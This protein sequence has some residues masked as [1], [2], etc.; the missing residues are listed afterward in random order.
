MYCYYTTTKQAIL[1][2]AI[3]SIFSCLGT[4]LFLSEAMPI[5]NPLA[6]EQ[7]GLDSYSLTGLGANGLDSLFTEKGMAKD[8]IMMPEN[9]LGFNPSN[10]NGD[11]SNFDLA[12]TPTYTPTTPSPITTREAT[13]PPTNQSTPT[14]TPISNSDETPTVTVI[15]TSSSNSTVTI[16]PSSPSFPTPTPSP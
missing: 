1:F 10:N 3:T 11:L 6:V 8:E 16:D 7:L 15:P 13:P 5:E 9:A 12:E 14:S 4:R 2:I